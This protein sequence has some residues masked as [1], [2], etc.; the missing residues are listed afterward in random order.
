[1]LTFK[2]TS[3]GQSELNVILLLLMSSNVCHNVDVTSYLP[4]THVQCKLFK[5]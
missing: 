2:Y 1:L 3:K 5:H 4:E